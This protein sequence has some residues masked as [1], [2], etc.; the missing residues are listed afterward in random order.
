MQMR[1]R[2]SVVAAG[3]NRRRR[4]LGKEGQRGWSGMEG[5]VVQGAVELGVGRHGKSSHLFDHL[6][7]VGCK[8]KIMCRLFGRDMKLKRRVK[9]PKSA[10]VL[11]KITL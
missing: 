7:W 8:G 11:H 5:R 10:E 3:G 1:L 4:S 2:F 9:F 6:L